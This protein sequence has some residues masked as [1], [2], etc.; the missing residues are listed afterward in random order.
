[1]IMTHDLLETITVGIIGIIWT[2]TI[3]A[4]DKFGSLD[5]YII[6]GFRDFY[7]KFL[8]TNLET[9]IEVNSENNCEIENNIVKLKSV[10]RTC[11]FWEAGKMSL[12]IVNEL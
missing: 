6:P 2:S 12:K 9:N 5:W 3:V 1:M 4:I 8:Y 11:F 10:I 7:L